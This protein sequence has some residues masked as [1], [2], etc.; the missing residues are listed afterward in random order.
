MRNTVGR[1]R[2]MLLGLS[3]AASAPV[4]LA[5]V[6]AAAQAPGLPEIRGKTYVLVHGGFNGGWVWAPVAERLRAE[7]HRVFAPTLTGMGERKHLLSRDVTLDTWITD[8]VNLVEAEELRD[9]V[10]VGY[11]FGGLPS[12]GVAD[13]MAE[14]VRRLV[15]LD[16]LVAQGGQSA[17]DVLPPEVAEQIRRGTAEEGGVPVLRAPRTVALPDGPVAQWLLRRFTPHPRATYEAP[18]RLDRPPGAGR[19]RTYVAFTSP[20]LPA[21]EPSR[22]WVRAQE[23]WDWTEIAAGHGAPVSVP[24]DVARLLAAAG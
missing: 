13:R 18:L 4:A 8:L 21:I 5:A 14:R 22:R 12:L 9:F 15:L 7:G 16:A 3:A 20:A 6:R 1:R 17:L 2:A 23:G 24:D 10:L 11:S 19:P